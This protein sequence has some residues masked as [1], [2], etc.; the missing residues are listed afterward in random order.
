MKAILKGMVV[1]AGLLVGEPMLAAECNFDKPVGA[2][3]GSIHIQSTGGSKPSY[4][5]EIVV[6]SSAPSCSKVEYYLDNTPQV[7]VIRGNSEP[8]SLSGTAP[9]SKKSLKVAR[10]TAYEDLAMAISPQN[11]ELVRRFGGCADD[12]ATISK[13]TKYDPDAQIDDLLAFIPKA[14]KAHQAYEDSAEDVARLQGL[15]AIVKDC[16]ARA[17]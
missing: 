15:L 5:A 1:L 10:C 14:I 11:K 4:S 17:P 8:E 12:K 9:I 2:C 7:T 13:L 16:K 3:Q 6:R